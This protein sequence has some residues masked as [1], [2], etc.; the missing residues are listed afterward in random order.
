MNV[1]KDVEKGEP[2]CTVGG[3][4]KVYF[5]TTFSTS[6]QGLEPGSSL[7][8]KSKTVMPHVPGG[9]V[10]P[11]ETKGGSEIFY[12]GL[13]SESVTLSEHTVS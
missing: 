6:L 10:G 8:D 3:N 2:F 13:D 11:G 4:A 5:E 12:S 9:P 1:G 7:L